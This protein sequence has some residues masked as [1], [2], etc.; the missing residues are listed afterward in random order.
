MVISCDKC[1]GKGSIVS[2]TCHRC[3]GHKVEVG[4]NVI[5]VEIERGMSEGHEIKFSQAADELPETTP[6][7]YLFINFD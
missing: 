7:S 4:E 1:G 5:Y 6:G 2:S 3:N